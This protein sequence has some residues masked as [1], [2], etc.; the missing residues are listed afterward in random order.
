MT[1][2]YVWALEA[3]P[4]TYRE[5][6]SKVGNFEREHLVPRRIEIAALY[7]RFFRIVAKGQFCIRVAFPEIHDGQIPPPK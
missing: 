6:C 7:R 1:H 5:F 4:R 3:L 2:S